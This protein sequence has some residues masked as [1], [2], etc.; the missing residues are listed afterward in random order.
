MTSKVLDTRREL[1]IANTLLKIKPS[2]PHNIDHYIQI[3]RRSWCSCSWRN[4]IAAGSG[5]M[6]MTENISYPL[7]APSPPTPSVAAPSMFLLFLPTWTLGKQHLAKYVDCWIVEQGVAPHLSP[8]DICPCW[9]KVRLNYNSA[10]T[11][12]YFQP[13]DRSRQCW[14]EDVGGRLDSTPGDFEGGVK[15]PIVK[16]KIV[17]ANVDTINFNIG[18]YRFPLGVNSEPT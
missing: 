8:R 9:G 3:D 12:E 15:P 17:K 6:T 1:S 18:V 5:Q 14:G 16:S 2:H 7:T 11:P 13:K 4:L 10:G